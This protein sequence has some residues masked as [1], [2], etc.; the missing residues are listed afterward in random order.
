MTTATVSEFRTHI[1]KYLDDVELKNESIV[2]FRGGKPVAE[3]IPIKP[4][5]QKLT[6]PK[7]IRIGTS[8]TEALLEDR[9]STRH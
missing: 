6:L 2:V 4:K 8:V 7:P 9:A 5:A 3:I 1:K